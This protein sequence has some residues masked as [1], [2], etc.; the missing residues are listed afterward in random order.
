MTSKDEHRTEGKLSTAVLQKF[1][2][3]LADAVHHQDVVVALLTEPA[4]ARNAHCEELGMTKRM[5]MIYMMI[6]M[7]KIVMITSK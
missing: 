3:V 1:I 6:M 2:E 4:H 7:L 5:I